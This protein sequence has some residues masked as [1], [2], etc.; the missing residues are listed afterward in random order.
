[1]HTKE[2]R[3][4]QK[5]ESEVLS[6]LYEYKKVEE[7]KVRRKEIEQE[8]AERERQIKEKMVYC[9]DYESGHS[10]SDLQQVYKWYANAIK[11]RGREPP[12]H[13]PHGFQVWNGLHSLYRFQGRS[14]SHEANGFRV[15]I[16]SH[17][18]VVFQIL[19]GSHYYF[20]FQRP[21]SSH[22]AFGFQ[23]LSGYYYLFYRFK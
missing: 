17:I 7:N 5:L 1:M 13:P 8:K 19:S 14:S 15:A 9:D 3:P 22:F 4:K 2:K 21:P 6:G 23:I 12:T 18:G 11:R 16:G 20:G 10:E